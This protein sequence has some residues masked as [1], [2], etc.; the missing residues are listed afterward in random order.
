MSRPEN[1]SEMEWGIMKAVWKS[2]QTSVRDVWE[3]VSPR[4][5]VAYTTVQ[6]YM[7]RLVEKGY[8]AKEKIGL[9]N[10]YRPVVREKKVIKGALDRFVFQAFEGS[11]GE[12]ASY[13]LAGKLDE[14]EMA[15]IRELFREKEEEGS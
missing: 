7:E 15:K 5:A 4:K 6:T 12:L 9:V 2:E 3:R 10:F 11:Y 14:S 13:L 1:L 8:L